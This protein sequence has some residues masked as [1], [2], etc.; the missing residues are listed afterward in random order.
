VTSLEKRDPKTDHLLT[1]HNAALVM[2]DLQPSQVASV[3]SM[4]RRTLVQNL[5]SLAQAAKLYRLPVVL[6]TINVKTGKNKPTIHQLLDVFGNIR[7]YDRTTLNAWE[8]LE[9]VA[10]VKATGRNKLIMSALW[11]EVG[12]TFST[13]DALRDGHEVY[14][15]V[16]ACGSTSVEAHQAGLQRMIQA[17]ARPVGWVSVL[18]ELQRDWARA[19]TAETFAKLLSA[20]EG[21]RLS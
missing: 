21:D 1:P 20:V 5:V 11:T 17:G 18:C 12:L 9:F 2:I 7:A 13:L 10:A 6:S 3:A 16:D 8:D 15:V 19:E 14:P 4:D